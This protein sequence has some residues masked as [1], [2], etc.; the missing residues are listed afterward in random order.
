MSVRRNIASGAPWE[1]AVAYSR[2]VRIGNVIEV[3]GTT[4]VDDDGNVVGL[5]DLYAQTR[6]VLQKIAN[7]L[8]EA[9]A[10][11]EDVV[12]T[13]IYFTDISQWEEAARAHREVFERVRPAATGVQVARLIHDDLLVEI[14]ATAI[15]ADPADG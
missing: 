7:A 4:A 15:I 3:S 10:G 1:N 14:E 9:G 2:A 6:F 13:R 11:V 12:R 8:N 5:G